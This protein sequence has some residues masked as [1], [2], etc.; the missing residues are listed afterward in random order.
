MSG[1]AGRAGIDDHGEAILITTRKYGESALTKLILQAPDPVGSCL[2][3]D[4]RGM[5]RAL[6]EVRT[7]S[8]ST[9]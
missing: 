4:K 9:S 1:R 2:T 3:D 8:Q 5:K 6:L 7:H